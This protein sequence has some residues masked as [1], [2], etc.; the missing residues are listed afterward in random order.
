VS[1]YFSQLAHGID[2]DDAFQCQVGLQRKPSGEIVRGDY[3]D[4]L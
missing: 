1:G 2:A 4:Q 3:S